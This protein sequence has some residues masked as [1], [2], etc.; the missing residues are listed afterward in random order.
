MLTCSQVLTMVTLS[1]TFMAM[2]ASIFGQNL[3]FSGA[4]TTVVRR[5]LYV[6]LQPDYSHLLLKD[7]SCSQCVSS[8][9]SQLERLFVEAI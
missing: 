4:E 6:G 9:Q 2:I 3:Y 8:V 1:L 7:L 5:L